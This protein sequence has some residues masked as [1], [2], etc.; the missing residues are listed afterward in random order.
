MNKRVL[1]PLLLLAC[2]LA[3]WPAKAVVE[4]APTGFLVRH[5]IAV[6]APPAKVYQA[7][8]GQVG[9]WWN[10]RHSY[11][12]DGANL[13]IDARAGGC[14]CERFP[15]GGGI[16][17]MRVVYVSPPTAVR[18]TGGLGPL[19]SSGLAGAMTWKLSENGT[20]TRLELTY[21]VG[22]FMQGGFEKMAPAVDGM[23]LEQV[24]RLRLFVET[25]KPVSQ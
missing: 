24:Q 22:G 21:S 3:A 2:G 17:H 4:V 10:P 16:E 5:D 11:T 25:G 13:S 20:G 8:V 19:Q 12:G 6:A 7:L 18:M 1:S 14:F 9:S 23:L 15:D